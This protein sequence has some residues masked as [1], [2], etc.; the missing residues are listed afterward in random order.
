MNCNVVLMFLG[1]SLFGSVSGARFAVDPELKPR[2]DKK[3]FGKDYPD[4]QRPAA[5]E[6]HFGHPFPEVQDG[7]HYDKDYVKDK[8]DDGGAWI[9][10]TRYDAARARLTKQK[11]TLKAAIAKEQEEEQELEGAEQAERAKETIS[12]EADAKKNKATKEAKEADKEMGEASKELGAATKEVEKEV[13]DLEDCKHKLAA[14]KDKL[15]TVLVKK[16]GAKK[17]K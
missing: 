14:A 13:K 5:K 8:N 3:F 4:D 15:Q 9:A 6:N 17:K 1:L 11:T 16:E 7:G 12:K 2:S 10:Q